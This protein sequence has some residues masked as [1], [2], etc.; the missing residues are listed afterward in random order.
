MSLLDNKNQVSE[1][2]LKEMIL[3]SYRK[4]LPYLGY[5][6]CLNIREF[7]EVI[8]AIT[9]DIPQ[10]TKKEI[11]D[12]IIAYKE[13]YYDYNEDDRER[14]ANEAKGQYRYEIDRTVFE[15]IDFVM[16]AY[17]EDSNLIYIGIK[18]TVDAEGKEVFTIEYKQEG[19]DKGLSQTMQRIA[20]KIYSSFE[21]AFMGITAIENWVCNIGLCSIE[22]CYISCVC[23]EIVEGLRSNR[24]L[25]KY[26]LK[27]RKNLE[28]LLGVKF[29]YV[30][31]PSEDGFEK[32]QVTALVDTT[33]YEYSDYYQQKSFYQHNDFHKKPY[34][35]TIVPT[36]VKKVWSEEIETNFSIEGK[37]EISGNA[38]IIRDICDDIVRVFPIDKFY[39]K[40]EPIFDA[41]MNW[42]IYNWQ[43]EAAI[44]KEVD[45]DE[46]EEKYREYEISKRGI[47]ESYCSYLE[48][49]NLL[50]KRQP[51]EDRNNAIENIYESLV[52]QGVLQWDK[53]KIKRIVEGDETIDDEE[54]EFG[55]DED[56]IS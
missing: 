52:C 22:S 6:S 26:F 45:T 50:N 31:L 17:I 47:L 7:E 13:E 35:E 25:P 56:S 3:S 29:L 5:N 46:I 48:D 32:I 37:L 21:E 18:Q 55:D 39:I 38:V 36:K 8:E 12:A 40:A 34:Q 33:V 16:S 54:D 51:R 9:I 42:S 43:Q 27:N 11:V 10:V 15:G 30:Y 2:E 53:E 1:E 19:N 23:E 4:V 41:K 44:I 20:R 24:V 14:I 49:C 28:D